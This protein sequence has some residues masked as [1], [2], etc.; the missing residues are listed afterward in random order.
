LNFSA[1]GDLLAASFG[2]GGAHTCELRAVLFN[3]SSV[4]DQ[5]FAGRQQYFGREAIRR[6]A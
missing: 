2:D 3:N 4:T 5:G 1:I 6:F